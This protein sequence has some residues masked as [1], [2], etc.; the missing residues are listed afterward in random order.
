[1][2]LAQ[3]GDRG[4]GQA[5]QMNKIG[6]KTVLAGIECWFWEVMKDKVEQHFRIM[7][8]RSCQDDKPG[9]V[10]LALMCE[11]RIGF[12]RLIIEPERHLSLTFGI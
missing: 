10:L 12:Q 3:E 6:K 2:S 4:Q 7:D 1:M 8:Y 9:L 11:Q 5:N